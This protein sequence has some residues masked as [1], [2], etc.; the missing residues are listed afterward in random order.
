[1]TLVLHFNAFT[2]RLDGGYLMGSDNKKV[3]AHMTAL[4]VLEY[5]IYRPETRCEA[6]TV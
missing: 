2:G 6:L 4:E 1:M 3:G 5:L